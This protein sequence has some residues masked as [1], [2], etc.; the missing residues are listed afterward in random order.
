MILK[1]YWEIGQKVLV[2]SLDG[3]KRKGIITAL[4]FQK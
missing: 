2:E 3:K 1:D 4:P